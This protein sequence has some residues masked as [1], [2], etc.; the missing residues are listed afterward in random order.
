MPKPYVRKMSATWWLKRRSYFYFMLRE[1]TAV[2]VAAYCVI[3]LVMLWRL[4]Q[5][6]QSFQNFLDQL[7]TLP[8]MLFHF[9]AL[10]FAAYHAITWFD[11]T[12]QIMVVRVGEEKVPPA[13]IAATNYLAWLAVTAVLVW[14]V[15]G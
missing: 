14:V 2:F 8:A 3:L 15:I 1:L 7:Q 4:K 10:V 5:G 12:P 6:P 11:L 9:F 13:V